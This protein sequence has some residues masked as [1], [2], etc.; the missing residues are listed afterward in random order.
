MLEPLDQHGRDVTD[1]SRRTPHVVVFE[2]A[3]DFVVGFAAVDHLKA[4]NDTAVHDDLVSR[5]RPLT[6]HAD[7]QRVA[8]A[9]FR[10][11]RQLLDTFVT[12]RA[13][14]EAVQGRGLCRGTLGPIHTQLP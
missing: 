5:D 10:P 14:D 9:T 3:H 12:V 6:E 4:A 7:V 8:V 1:V 11:R 2:H 13:W